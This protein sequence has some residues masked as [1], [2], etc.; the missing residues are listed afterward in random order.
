MNRESWLTDLAIEVVPF[1]KGFKLEP[2]KLTMGWPIS[3]GK[4]GKTQVIGEC[5]GIESSTGGV[6]ELFISPVIDK[7]LQVAGVVCHEL[8]HVA[9][10][11]EA[12][13]KGKFLKVCKHVGLTIGKPTHVMPGE[14]LNESLK[15]ITERLGK[16]PHKAMKLVTIP[17]KPG[18]GVKLVCECGFLAHTSRKW[19]EEVGVPTCA[20]GRKLEE[21]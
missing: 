17:K 9:A 20:C 14:K 15:R 16:Y 10:G 7:P 18:S 1:F 12:Q 2:F 19:V 3:R 5:H 13:H 21:V 8:A 4:P 11:I 6:H